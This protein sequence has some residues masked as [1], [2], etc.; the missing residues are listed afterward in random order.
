LNQ[1]L[2]ENSN[3]LSKAELKESIAALYTLVSEL[4]KNDVD[5]NSV[6]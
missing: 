1:F 6:R 2:K 4:A 3:K 5:A